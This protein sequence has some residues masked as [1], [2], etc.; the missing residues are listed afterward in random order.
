MKYLTLLIIFLLSNITVSKAQTMGCTD[1]QASNY[2]ASATINDGSC[3]YNNTSV[4]PILALS[5]SDSVIE[6]SGLIQWNNTFWTHNDNTDLNL[7]ALD[8][9]TGTITKKTALPNCFNIDWEDMAQDSLFVYVG[10]F[11]NNVNGNR[12][13]LQILRI[14][15]SSINANNPIIDTIRFSYSNQTNFASSGANN[16]NFDCEAFVVS[17]DSIFLFTKQ[18][19]NKKTS[20]YVL[21]K[22][23]GIWVAT[24][25]DSLSVQGLVTGATYLEDKKAVAL[26]GYTTFL[27]PFITLLYDFKQH[28]FFK[29]NNRRL[30]V[31]LPFHQTEGISSLNGYRFY[32]SNE[33]FSNS[34]ITT[35]QAIHLFDLSSFLE[36]YYSATSIKK[37]DKIT[38]DL[39]ITP[40]PTQNA[41]YVQ[42]NVK[43]K[44]GY[45]IFNM[46]GELV[47]KGSV[48]PNE[49]IDI[50]HFK[51]GTYTIKLETDLIT[52]SIKFIKQ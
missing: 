12:T 17:R 43:Q 4:S 6:T 8:T 9:L 11:G 24:L 49:S 51:N 32:V 34:S 3:I 15:K 50:T 2:N 28:H 26:C 35:P 46:S 1:T 45:L 22:Q 14:S 29:G 7:Y 25:K 5:I 13:N 41:L 23:P 19:V 52:K 30:N 47:A 16:T 27:Q 31:S 38:Y 10:D 36:P 20:L 40:N 42:S 21:S 44:I 33:K 39:S 48:E 18:W 37:K